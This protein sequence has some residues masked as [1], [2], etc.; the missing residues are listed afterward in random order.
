MSAGAASGCEALLE[1]VAR[2]DGVAVRALDEHGG[3]A[4]EVTYAA[5]RARSEACARA[6]AGACEAGDAVLVVER[7]AAA[8]AAWL[9]GG[10]S[11]GCW[12]LPA[13]PESTDRELAHLIAGSGAR[14]VA[15][16]GGARVADA[17]G[18]RAIS[19][20]EA[21]RNARP[22]GG[23]VILRTSGT[24]GIPKLVQRTLGSLDWV[25]SNVREATGLT[26]R[27][28]VLSAIPAWHSYGIENVVLGPLTAG[29]TVVCC[30]RFDAVVC[31]RLLR[32]GATV[33]PGVPMMFESLGRGERIE[34]GVTLR[35]GYSA[36]STLAREIGAAFEQRWGREAGQLYGATDVGSVTFNDPAAPAFSPGTVG[37]GMR[38]VSIR[39]IGEDGIDVARGAE[40]QVAIKAP[41]M[42]S[43]Y[44][45]DHAME[46]IDGH[47]LMGDL[48]RLDGEGRLTISGMLKFLI[49]VGGMKVN[50]AEVEE[51]LR[52][53]PSVGDCAVV[54]MRVSD[55]M[56]R[57]RAIVTGR[58]GA[59]PEVGALRA[60]VKE[61]LAGYKV[62][63]VI[64]VWERLPRSATG[65][66]LRRSLEEA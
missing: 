48:G 7:R 2:R 18:L 42:L 65:K 14:V 56:Q 24:T 58:G 47:L 55:G 51:V 59:E 36:G 26:D 39:I 32:E 12:V 9:L 38:G 17:H 13:P 27:D 20:G 53:H 31:E 8:F 46:L 62:P 54:G 57:V 29:A 52:E 30:A 63:R 41:S 60:W 43:R 50:P 49:D 4:G 45:G 37:V 64:E 25:A 15:G 6:V 23:G 19:E 28:V 3:V 1:A 5:L 66:L 11:A 33:F 61:R 44:M 40:G 35:L 34:G 10:L 16:E 21:G 22:P